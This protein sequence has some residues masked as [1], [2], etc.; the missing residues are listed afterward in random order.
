MKLRFNVQAAYAIFTQ[1]AFNSI[2]RVLMDGLQRPHGQTRTSKQQSLT[3]WMYN[4][5]YPGLRQSRERALNQSYLSNHLSETTRIDRHNQT[6][7]SQPKQHQQLQAI[8]SALSG[9][10]QVSVLTMGCPL[11]L[12]M[13]QLQEIPQRIQDSQFNIQNRERLMPSSL[14]LFPSR[15]PASRSG[16]TT[17]SIA[18]HPQR[19]TA[20]KRSGGHWYAKNR[21]RHL[22]H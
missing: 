17:R 16:G 12:V 15:E 2:C 22:N 11:T 3:K 19:L 20:Q 7:R 21:K 5:W 6:S 10:H 4:H 14:C 18:Y 13:L 9:T 1:L 8:Q